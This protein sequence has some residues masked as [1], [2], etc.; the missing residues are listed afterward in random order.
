[1]S[2]QS[3]LIALCRLPGASSGRA[4]RREAT[5]IALA[6]RVMK[7]AGA[8][9]QLTL[10]IGIDEPRQLNL[11]RDGDDYSP[12]FDFALRM[13]ATTPGILIEAGSDLADVAEDWSVFK[14][15]T[16]SMKDR[17]TPPAGEVPG[18]HMLHPLWFH[19]DLPRSVLLRSWREIHAD[20]ALRVHVGA[21][22]Y[23]QHLVENTLVPGVA[24]PYGGF[25][26]FHFPSERA[27]FEGYFDS[28]RGRTEIRHDIRHFIKGVP[29]R[30]FA[31]EIRIGAPAPQLTPQQ[32]D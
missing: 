19:E 6:D 17:A 24:P 30:L 10:L 3:N 18:I 27:P 12:P 15:G 21:T 1:M 22:S 8:P 31:R 28:D 9:A 23:E 2:S 26:E 7:T 4:E 13:A 20:L 16:T 11:Y 5:A 32:T 29:P 14:V 25:S